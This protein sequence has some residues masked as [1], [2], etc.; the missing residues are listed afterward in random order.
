[1]TKPTTAI[2]LRTFAT[3]LLLAAVTLL[4]TSCY[5]APG[6]S[7][8]TL[9]PVLSWNG[10]PAQ[11]IVIS[12]YERSQ[13]PSVELKRPDGSV[14]V[15]TGESNGP[16][17]TVLVD[18]LEPDTA[19]LYRVDGDSEWHDFRTMPE[20][21]DSVS[22]AVLGDFQPMSRETARTTA[23]VI[24]K[25]AELDP[26]FVVQIGD[27]AERG[28]NA[29]SVRLSMSIYSEMGAETATL[30][31]VGNHD[32][33]SGVYL[34][35]KSADLFNAVF[36]ATNRGLNEGQGDGWYSLTTGP[37]H[38]AVVDTQAEDTVFEAQVEWLESDLRAASEAGVRWLFIVGHKPLLLTADGGP[39]MRWAEVILPLAARY[40]VDAVFWGHNHLLEHM[41][42]AYG[43]D[44]RVFDADD[45]AATE[46]THFFSVLP[47]GA[48]IEALYPG[49]FTSKV[50]TETWP[51]VWSGSG[52]PAELTFDRHG[53]NHD[54]AFH[55]L[56]GVR[57][58]DPQ[59]YRDAASYYYWPFDNAADEA[60]GIYSD[61]PSIRYTDDAEFFGYTYA[62]TSIGYL[63]VEIDGDTCT[64]SSHYVDGPTGEQGTLMRTPGGT[65]LVWEFH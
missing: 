57:Y 32:Y 63:W 43:A 5:T 18:G 49:M 29:A 50:S 19:Y 55:E 11:S 10:D 14:D 54:L 17:S 56:P 46:T 52:E 30:A 1:M 26:A 12:W 34:P 28:A 39:N 20:T 48:R 58:Q 16:I 7:V 15:V 53:W 22:F 41:E 24:D 42:Y 45:V 4:V 9:Q 62:E 6:F 36:P 35:R 51:F 61:D 33:Y 60:A 27:F 3:V 65:P 40:D 47:A 44:G 37:I 64:I 23:L 21:F 25:V 13:E 59:R 8:S 2:K 38:F 31:T